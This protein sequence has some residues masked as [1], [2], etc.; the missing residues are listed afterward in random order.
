MGKNCQEMNKENAGG[1][2]VCVCVCNGMLFSHKKEGNSAVHDN[3]D[4]EGVMLSEIIHI[5]EDK[6]CMISLIICK[7]MLPYMVKRDFADMIKLRI[8]RWKSI[9][10]SPSGPKGGSDSIVGNVNAEPR[11]NAWKRPLKLKKARKYS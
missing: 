2:C 10:D 3:M 9:L 8:S 4:L 6:Y 1:V 7:N 5:K 11:S